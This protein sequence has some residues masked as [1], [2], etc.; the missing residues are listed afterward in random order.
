MKTITT[1]LIILITLNV[2]GQEKLSLSEAIAIG[3]ENNYDLEIIRKTEDVA[4][5][6][7]NWGNAG[8]LPSVS[9]SLSGYEN[10]YFNNSEDY[11]TQTISPDVT[12]SWN[13]FDGF[14]AKMT[15]QKLEKLEE[16]SKGNTAILVESTIQ[17]IILAYNN[18]LLQKQM[19]DV[20]K[21][22]S[23]LSGDRCQRT[24]TSKEIG[25]STTYES[26]QAKTSWLEDQSNYLQ[27][28]V[29]YE[30]AIRTLNYTL[31]VEDNTMWILSSELEI[32][33]A[34]YQLEDLSVKLLANNQTLRNQY[35]SQS[36]AAKETAIT[37]SNFYPSLSLSSG[38]GNTWLDYNYAGSTS[39]YS[40]N[41]ADVYVGLS[42][43]FNIFNG[44]ITKR[45]YQIA[46][47]Y[48]EVEQ[49]TTNQMKHSLNNQLLQL[50]S[51]YNVQKA[52]L[53]LAMETEAAAKLNLELSEAK[54]K[55]GA[56]NSFNYRDVQIVYMNA[57]I[58]KFQAI[59]NLVDSNTDLL[60]ITGGII[61]EFE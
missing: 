3:L 34:D 54:L 33:T 52:I 47:I 25:A 15:K 41:T 50:F 5:M 40:S 11:S 8:A 57:A 10:Y 48:E 28:K 2:W 35:L 18:C 32:S 58:T 7:N 36:L 44:G 46:Q 17:D 14:S 43:S 30:N 16:Q 24:I 31:A 37:K 4:S 61:R 53:E 21:E 23:D 12:L 26:L 55:S 49:V 59:Y 22:L 38:V 19:V 56:I 42:L 20:Y 29:N 1:L 9:F 6:N 13:V 51:N 60:R 45:N 39:N 27:Q